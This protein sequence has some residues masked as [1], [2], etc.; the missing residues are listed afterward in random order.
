MSAALIPLSQAEEYKDTLPFSL[1]HIP[2]NFPKVAELCA[3]VQ[4]TTEPSP[5]TKAKMA[6]ELPYIGWLVGALVFVAGHSF[7]LILSSLSAFVHTL[8]LQYVE[9]FPKFL[10]GGGREF[11]PLSK[12]FKHVYVEGK[13]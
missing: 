2:H 13:K 8:R 7:N 5:E 10:E 12:G 11:E 4:P 9:F 6:A 3:F 1:E